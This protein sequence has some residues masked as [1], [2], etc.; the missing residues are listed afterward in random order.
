MQLRSGD[1]RRQRSEASRS[2]IIGAAR[3]ILADGGIEAVQVEAVADM[4]DMSVQTIYNR[5]GRRSQLLLAVGEQAMEE[6]SQLLGDAF[7]TQGTP[8]ERAGAIAA[9][10]MTF[11][12]EHPSEFQLL[13]NPVDDDARERLGELQRKEVA[14]LA[15]LLRDAWQSGDMALPSDPT[16]VAVALWAMM[17]GI[18]ALRW[19]ATQ[20]QLGQAS[21]EQVS[22]TAVSI[23]F[24][25]L[26]SKTAE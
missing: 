3:Q 13:A 16:Q 17:D 7:D 1:R 6:C 15:Q 12:S 14:R 21:F 20:L 8:R 4:V 22:E 5:V 23:M 19:K 26:G 9:A 25:G 10:Y 24:S 18:V 2:A 11:A